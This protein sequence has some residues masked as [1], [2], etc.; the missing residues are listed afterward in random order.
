MSNGDNSLSKIEHIVVLMLENRSFDNLMGWLYD[1]SNNPPFNVVP[2]DF[3]G[4]YGKN[5]SNLTPEGRVVPAGKSNDARNPQPNPG[6][7]FEDVYSQIYDVPKVDFEDV[8]NDP[9][10]A[11][12]MQGFIRNYAAQKDKP[13]DPSKIM[14]SL[15]PKTLP[16]F[17][18]LALLCPL[19]SLVRI[20]SHANILQPI[21]HPC[22]HFVCLRQ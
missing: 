9:P 15:T 3:D 8:P 21:F 20:D 2:S 4:L 17:S 12:G 5:L 18:S 10:F 6:E 16:V 1:P 14:G 13:A 19:R 11:P 22:R 7:P